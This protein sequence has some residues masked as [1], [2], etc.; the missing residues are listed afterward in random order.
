MTKG[1]WGLTGAM[2]ANPIGAIIAGMIALGTAVVYAW[3]K[4]EGFRAFLYGVWAAIKEFGTMLYERFIEPMMAWGKMLVG[5]FTLDKDMILA[6]MKDMGAVMDKMTTSSI[7]RMS[8]AFTKGWNDGVASFRNEADTAMGGMGA[9]GAVAGAFGGP[10]APGA[11]SPSSDSLKDTTKSMANG[12]SNGG[13]KYITI[14]L[15]NLVENFNVHTTN[16]KEAPD[17]VKEMMQRA[18]LE[19]LNSANQVNPSNG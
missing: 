17:Q 16:M 5:V 8:S 11:G 10:V 9:P 4:F 7:D 6:G 1:V 12:I 15:Q 3:N 13:Q 14:K 2:I 19:V 18:L